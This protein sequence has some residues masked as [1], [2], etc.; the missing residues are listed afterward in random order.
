[1][2]WPEHIEVLT[3]FWSWQLLGEP[4]YEGSPLR[5]HAAVHARTPF[6]P[7]HYERW[8]ELFEATVDA[9]YAG[10]LA[11]TAKSRARKVAAATRRMLATGDGGP[12]DEPLSVVP[13][14]PAS[15]R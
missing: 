1:M 6:T 3:A 11:E 8:L 4:G 7:A 9:G 2:H 5:A 14:T 15:R 13:R 10:P 12:A